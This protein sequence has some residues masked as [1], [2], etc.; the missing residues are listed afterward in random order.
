MRIYFKYILSL[1]SYKKG[2]PAPQAGAL[3]AGFTLVE[4]IVSIA[5]AAIIITS[6]VIQQSQWNDRLAVSTQAYELAL[7]IRQAQVY[8]LGVREDTAGSGD[9]FNIGYGIYFD[10]G[11]NTQYIFFADRN[12]NQVYDNGEAIGD[13]IKLTGGVTIKDVCGAFPKCLYSGSGPMRSADISFLRPD[14]KAAI[15]IYNNGGNKKD[16]A[17]ITI[18]LKSA[19]GSIR[20][21]VVQDNGQV[22]IQ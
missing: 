8:S 22:S 6:I 19:G 13:P 1:V 15:G 3:R 4:L 21:I 9:K 18:K 10:N 2:P 20:S 16:G 7:M 5:I 14:P 12:N 11:D 17:P